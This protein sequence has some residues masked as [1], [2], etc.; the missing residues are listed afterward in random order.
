MLQ[1]PEILGILIVVLILFGA[2]KLPEL[3]RGLGQGIKEFKR[4][5]RDVQDDLQRAIDDTDYDSAPPKSHSSSPVEAPAT[6]SPEVSSTDTA[7]PDEKREAFL[8]G[9]DSSSKG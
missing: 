4:A 6:P 3:A 1:W 8:E 2:K 7:E 5:T 9:K